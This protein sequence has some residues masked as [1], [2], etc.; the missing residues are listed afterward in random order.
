VIVQIADADTDGVIDGVGYR[1][2]GADDPDFAH[3]FR[4]HRVDVRAAAIQPRIKSASAEPAERRTRRS[5]RR[6]R[7]QGHK[8]SAHKIDRYDLVEAAEQAAVHGSHGKLV[9]K[10]LLIVPECG[11]GVPVGHRGLTVGSAG[12][13]IHT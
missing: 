9:S 5:V 4:A 11:P 6:P 7:Q 13:R 10:A 3:P 12:W 1:G 2:C 8:R